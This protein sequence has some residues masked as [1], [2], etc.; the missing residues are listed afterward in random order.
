LWSLLC[1][2]VG[3]GILLMALGYWTPSFL[4]PPKPVPKLK[5][6]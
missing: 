6:R 4:Q 1:L 5:R 3:T 2:T